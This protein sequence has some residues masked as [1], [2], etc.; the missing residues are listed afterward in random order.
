MEVRFTDVDS[1]HHVNHLKILEWTSHARIQFIDDF[2][3]KTRWLKKLDYVLVHI[4][5]NF[6]KPAHYPGEI[7]IETRVDKVGGKSLT[8]N[9][10]VIHGGEICAQVQC[11]N[12]FHNKE[13][14]QVVRIPVSLREELEKV[15]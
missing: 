2:L 12:V 15:N 10:T 9:Y 14:K 4:E 1:Q 6:I 8:T 13:T 3:W 5:A 7:S 11:V